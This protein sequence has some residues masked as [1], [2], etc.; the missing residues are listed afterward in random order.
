[1]IRWLWT[2]LTTPDAYPGQPLAY[3]LNQ[4]GHAALGAGIG[5]LCGPDA[6]LL[7]LAIYVALIE[8]PQ[9]ALWG[10]SLADGAEDTG[11][12]LIGALAAAIDWRIALVA[13]LWITAGVQARRKQRFNKE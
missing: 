3:A 7:G 10:G 4:F 11:F 9:L 2:Y 1:M 8:L 13:A 12:V 5:I 6:L